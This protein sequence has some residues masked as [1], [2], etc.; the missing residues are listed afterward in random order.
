MTGTPMS[1]THFMHVP[2]SLLV[3]SPG[4]PLALFNRVLHEVPQE[5]RR[6]SGFPN[7]HTEEFICIDDGRIGSHLDDILQDQESP[8][9]AAIYKSTEW[10]Q[11][12]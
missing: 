1:S 4:N 3:S 9:Y 2:R 7:R 8:E 12:A 5:Y 11:L 10:I 6:L